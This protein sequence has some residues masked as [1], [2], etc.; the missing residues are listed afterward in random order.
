M[1]LEVKGVGVV[2]Q[3]QFDG[4]V[5][6]DGSFWVMSDLSLDTPSSTGSANDEIRQGPRNHG[7]TCVQVYLEKMK[8]FDTLWEDVY[9]C[10][11]GEEGV[12]IDAE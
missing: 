9:R 3:G 6:L 10:N 8:P 4:K 1:C 7:K 2:T 11:S 5:A 12:V